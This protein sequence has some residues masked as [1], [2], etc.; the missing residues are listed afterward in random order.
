MSAIIN[1]FNLGFPWKTED[2]FL[3]CV[4]HE[5]FYPKGNDNLGP[6]ESLSGRNLGNDF[7]IKDGYRMYHGRTIPGF[8]AHPHRGFETITVVREG[9]VDHSDSA[10]G[11]GRYGYGDVQ[12]MTA[13]KGL[14]HAEMFPLLNKTKENPFELF[15]IWINLPK[16]NKMVQPEFKMLWNED[17]AEETIKD[18]KGNESTIK[19][20]AGPISK[21]TSAPAPNSWA[22]DPN[23]EVAVWNIKIPANGELLLPKASAKVNRNIYFFKGT[24]LSIEDKQIPV[25]KGIKVKPNEDVLLKN[26]EEEAHILLLQGKPIAEPV[27]Q[28]GPFVMNTRQEIQEAIVDYQ[29]TRFGGWPWS[30]ADHNHGPAI[31]R[32]AKHA[33]GTVE[34]K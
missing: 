8:P 5:D 33:N 9:L 31:G 2:P 18:S 3:F 16:V 21:P 29:T 24:T 12:W 27:V 19:I 34:K 7:T 20:V 15:Q 17:Q 14:Q 28:H 1:T 23:N 32:F 13:G 10:G 11:A 30:A 26:G 4:H 25:Y 22:A 6:A